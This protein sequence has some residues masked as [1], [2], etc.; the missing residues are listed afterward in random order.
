MAYQVHLRPKGSKT[1]VVVDM[2]RYQK[3]TPKFGDEI[4]CHDGAG[5]PIRAKV[6]RVEPGM[7]DF[8]G[9]FTDRVYA[10]EIG[11]A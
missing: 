4:P 8:R 3:P 11:P 7:Y 10:E 9:E 1:N 5:N 6:A 2:R